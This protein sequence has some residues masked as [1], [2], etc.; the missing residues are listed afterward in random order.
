MT[1]LS[2][3]LR[4]LR[5]QLTSALT[6]GDG[7]LVRFEPGPVEVETTAAVTRE[8]GVDAKVRLGCR[9]ELPAVTDPDEARRRGREAL[10]GIHRSR[11]G[12]HPGPCTVEA[13]DGHVHPP[14]PLDPSLTAVSAED[15]FVEA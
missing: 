1:E 2:A 11:P 14:F 7:Q 12:R 10:G 9:P 5:Q 6:D 15:L 8:A 3:E 4:E 13:T